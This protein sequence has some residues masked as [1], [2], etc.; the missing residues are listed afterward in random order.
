MGIRHRL[1]NW[2]SGGELTRFAAMIDIMSGRIADPDNTSFTGFVLLR[3][4]LAAERDRTAALVKA[5]NDIIWRS[6]SKPNAT[7]KAMVAIAKEAV[8]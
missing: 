1:A 3:A 2:I 4:S 7:V 6:T 8:K 5:M